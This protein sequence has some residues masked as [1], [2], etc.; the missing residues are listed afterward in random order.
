MPKLTKRCVDALRSAPGRD[1]FIWDSE[2]RGFAVRMKPSDS[3][4]FL[5]RYRT[6]QGRSLSH[7]FAKSGTLTP[8]E[9]RTKA[10]AEAGDG[11]VPSVERDKARNKALTA[12]ECAT[13]PWRR[14]APGWSQRGSNGRNALR[15]SPSTKGAS[16]ATLSRGP[17]IAPSA[18][19]RAPTSADG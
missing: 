4:S 15:P 19:L 6:P 9:A 18:N 8:D 13:A 12:A 14:R 10:R 3:A 11:G 16:R 5:V 17:A 2:L 7:A 1:L